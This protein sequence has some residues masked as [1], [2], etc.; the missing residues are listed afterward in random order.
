M[1][2]K[3]F[4]LFLRGGDFGMSA[5]SSQPYPTLWTSWTVAP[6]APFTGLHRQEHWRRLP[7]L[8]Q[9][10]FPTQGSNPHLQLLPCR[11]ILYLLSHLGS[12]KLV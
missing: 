2:S 12:P 1:Y 9:K 3:V 4:I 11:Q 7:F 6:Q 5:Q 8:L 10:I